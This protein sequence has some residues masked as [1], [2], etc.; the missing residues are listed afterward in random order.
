MLARNQKG[1]ILKYMNNAVI[2]GQIN[3]V[4]SSIINGEELTIVKDFGDGHKAFSNKTG[5]AVAIFAELDE[6]D[7]FNISGWKK[8]KTKSLAEVADSLYS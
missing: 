2:N 8:H 1:C 5:S 7:F 3:L 6:G 4:N